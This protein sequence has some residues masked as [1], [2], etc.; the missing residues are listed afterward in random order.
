MYRDLKV[1]DPVVEEIEGKLYLRVSTG[2]NRYGTLEFRGAERF[3]FLENGGFVI[4]V[5]ETLPYWESVRFPAAYR[6]MHD[7]M[8]AVSI[9]RLSPSPVIPKKHVELRLGADCMI[10]MDYSKRI[11]SMPVDDFVIQAVNHLAESRVLDV[12]SFNGT[13]AKDITDRW[14]GGASLARGLRICIG[15]T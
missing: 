14:E 9:K 2:H 3:L 11:V 12:S 4:A 13:F 15:A 6:P 1:S 7:I 8:N 10:T 5:Y